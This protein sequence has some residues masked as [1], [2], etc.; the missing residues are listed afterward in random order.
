MPEET[1]RITTRD[2]RMETFLVYPE[3][4]ARERCVLL[5]HDNPWET[6]RFGNWS[7]RP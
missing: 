5:F 6:F 1:T 4:P 7:G 2:G 3:P